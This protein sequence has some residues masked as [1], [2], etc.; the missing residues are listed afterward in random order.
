MTVT[1]VRLVRPRPAQKGANPRPG[2]P[3]YHRLNLALNGEEDMMLAYLCEADGQAFSV[4]LRA[5]IRK[6]Y[7]NRTGGKP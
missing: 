2:G 4:L 1:R 7:R 3:N 6:E 5:L